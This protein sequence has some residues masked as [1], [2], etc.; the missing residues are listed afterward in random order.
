[1][2]RTSGYWN[3]ESS[4]HWVSARTYPSTCTY[5][6]GTTWISTCSPTSPTASSSKGSWRCNHE[7]ETSRYQERRQPAGGQQE[8][9]GVHHEAGGVGRVR[10]HYHQER[11]RGVPDARRGI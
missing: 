8:D 10:R 11:A 9:H 1:M 3:W 5:S 6:H 4:R 7:E 2:T